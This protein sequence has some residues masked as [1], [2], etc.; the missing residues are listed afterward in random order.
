MTAED[1]LWWTP[2]HL[3]GVPHA[4]LL[5]AGMIR[6]LSRV[7]RRSLDA[8]LVGIA[9]AELWRKL[10]RAPQ[11]PRRA[12]GCSEPDRPGIELRG[13]GALGLV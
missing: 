11:C 8:S 5:T 2:E 13:W 6:T 10:S 7:D 1:D 3:L 9:D 4:R 12:N